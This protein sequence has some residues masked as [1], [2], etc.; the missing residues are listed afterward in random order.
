MYTILYVLTDSEKL[1]YYNQLLISLKSLRIHM[2]EQKI[3]V[4]L[5]ES[6]FEI[7]EKKKRTELKDVFHA[8]TI[9]VEI[10]DSYS[11][12]EKSRYLK[13]KTRNLVSGTILFLD[14][15][16]VI[17]GPLPEILSDSDLAM[18][19]DYNTMFTERS[20]YEEMASL[21]AKYG[22]NLEKNTCYFN[23]GVIW[24]KD[25]EKTRTFFDAWFSEWNGK[26]SIAVLDQPSLNHINKEMG[27]II[28]T[29]DN[30]YNLQINA[31]PTPVQY[32]SETMI[33][34][35][36][37]MAGRSPYLLNDSY[38]QSLP[39]DSEEIDRI[40]TAPLSAFKTSMIVEVD[41]RSMR[42]LKSR[43]FRMLTPFYDFYHRIR[44]AV[45]TLF[46]KR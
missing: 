27:G 44:R 30:K 3:C 37:N 32:I 43:T 38:Y 34:H 25:T 29:L 24:A 36:F 35:Y 6:T 11:Q 12:K 20:D 28:S 39:Y 26:R 5:D 7:L 17:A 16:T 13:L 42:F 45:R 1:T 21:N 46:R 19:P 14:T 8:D 23:G 2:P 4:L 9:V 31:V 15:D 33:I 40:I 10:N 41:S 18:V 22:Y